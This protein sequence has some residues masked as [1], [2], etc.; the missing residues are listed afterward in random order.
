MRTAVRLSFAAVI[1]LSA[2]GALAQTEPSPLYRN[3]VE[4]FAAI[5]P[6]APKSRDVTYVMKDGMKRPARQFYVDQGNDHFTLTLVKVPEARGGI[7]K[8]VIDY[9]ADQVKKK[10]TVRF[11]FHN[12]Y[13]PGVPGQQLNLAEANG[14]QLRASVYMWDHQ[15]YIT[16]ASAMPGS[17]AALQF[18]QS[19]TIL[20]DKGED[21]N[22]GQGSPPC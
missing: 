14:N 11:N 4:H 5:F 6:S 3:P 17:G 18:E 1:L 13:D 21:L 16:E 10:G 12:C 9:A 19:I 8:D 2:A 20:D 7:D 15:L 22:T